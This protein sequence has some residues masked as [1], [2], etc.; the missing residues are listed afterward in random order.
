VLRTS[1]DVAQAWSLLET[2][3]Q[4]TPSPEFC[5]ALSRLAERMGLPEKRVWLTRRLQRYH[6]GDADTDEPTEPHLAFVECNRG[7]D[8]LL[9]LRRQMAD[10]TGLAATDITGDF[11]VRFKDESSVGSAV[12]REWMDLVAQHA[13][14]APNRQLLV[15]YDGGRSFLPSPSALFVN[16][17]WRGDFELLGRILGLAVWHQVTLDLPLH[18]HLCALLLETEGL[19]RPLTAAS[20]A[21]LQAIDEELYRNKVQ[22]LLANDVSLLGYDMPFADPL[23]PD[24]SSRSGAEV[25][26]EMLSTKDMLAGDEQSPDMFEVLQ[27]RDSQVCL[28]STPDVYVSEDNKHDFVTKLADWRLRRS[29]LGP[30]R[31]ILSGLR[32]VVPPAVMQ[33]IRRMLTADDLAKLLAGTRHIDTADWEQNTRFVGGLVLSS[34]EVKWFWHIVRGWFHQ[35]RQ[36]YLQNLLQFATGSR[37]VPVGGFAQLV[38][39]NGGKH[40]FT[41]AKG[42]HLSA[43]SLPTSHACICTVD[44]PPWDSLEV[45]ESKLLAAVEAGHSRFD[46]GMGQ[47]H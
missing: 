46:E 21:Q 41:L 13:F 23:I 6:R 2:V 4:A 37:R 33:E 1:L 34:R 15:S 30:V 31:A 25:L 18:S 22:W 35:G 44:L 29:L 14:L 42:V 47:E 26:P 16:R 19:E 11:E 45:A 9:Q 17:H 27:I 12:M 32:A 3:H 5:D 20:V 8:Q 7:A 38:G 24:G 36:D 43:S 40:Q 28:A 10:K 39:F